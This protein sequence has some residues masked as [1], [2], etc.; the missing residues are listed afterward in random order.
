MLVDL[1]LKFLV[2]KGEYKWVNLVNQWSDRIGV[3]FELMKI[4]LFHSP[5]M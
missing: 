5:A 4:V 1:D 2:R 3:F